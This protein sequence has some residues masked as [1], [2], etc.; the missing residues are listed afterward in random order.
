MVKSRVELRLTQHH[1]LTAIQPCQL[2]ARQSHF[3]I[4]TQQLSTNVK[5]NAVHCSTS[6]G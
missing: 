2:I 3:P 5:T 1:P 4:K 6:A